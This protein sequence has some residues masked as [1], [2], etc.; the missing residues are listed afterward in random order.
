M[1]IIAM[2]LSIMAI[3]CLW[4]VY[5]LHAKMSDHRLKHYAHISDT[6][7]YLQY[8]INQMTQDALKNKL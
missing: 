8:R 1:L 5:K 4:F 2:L 6:I 3:A 7:N